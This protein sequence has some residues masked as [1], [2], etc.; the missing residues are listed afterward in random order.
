MSQFNVGTEVALITVLGFGARRVTKRVV[1]QVWS[2]SDKFALVDHAGEVEGKYKW[3]PSGKGLAT[4]G[5]LGGKSNYRYSLRGHYC[6]VWTAAH[7]QEI[8]ERKLEAARAERLTV[9]KDAVAKLE[10]RLVTEAEL[11]ALEAALGL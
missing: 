5:P 11:A 9:V 1:G 2:K 8:V 7:E 10:R 6:E 4:A 3:S